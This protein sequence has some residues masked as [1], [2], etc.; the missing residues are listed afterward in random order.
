MGFPVVVTPRFSKETSSTALCV[1]MVGLPD[2]R[3]DPQLNQKELREQK[4]QSA[5]QQGSSVPRMCTDTWAGPA[6][7]PT[8]HLCGL[9]PPTGSV[10]AGGGLAQNRVQS[11]PFPPVFP[12]R[13]W[14]V[15]RAGHGL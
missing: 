11:A 7:V 9:L 6:H 5:N 15:Q 13:E 1:H 14:D 8:P 2:K 4:W 12:L 3:L 10:S